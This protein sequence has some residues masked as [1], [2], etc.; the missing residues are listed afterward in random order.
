MNYGKKTLNH[1]D[2]DIYY[3]NDTLFI[4]R[5]N[6]MT[7]KNFEKIVDLI[8]YT[9]H[10]QQIFHFPNQD[11]VNIHLFFIDNFKLEPNVYLLEIIES[12]SRKVIYHNNFQI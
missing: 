2:I 7:D 1:D 11:I 6:F 10:Y 12:E 4:E 8:V 3:K 5:N 9:K